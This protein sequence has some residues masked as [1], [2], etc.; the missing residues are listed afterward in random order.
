MKIQ[1]KASLSLEYFLHISYIEAEYLDMSQHIIVK[2][3]KGLYADD[4]HLIKIMG[5]IKKDGL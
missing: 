5:D 1:E 2:A 4:T 3:R